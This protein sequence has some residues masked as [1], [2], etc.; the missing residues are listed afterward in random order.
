MDFVFDALANGLPL[1]R[2]TV[3]FHSTEEAVEIAVGRSINAHGEADLVD[4]ACR[5]RG[6]RS[7][8]RTD[9]GP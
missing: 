6:Y 8:I 1:K 3:V 7:S 9:Q 4:A 5:F 2:L